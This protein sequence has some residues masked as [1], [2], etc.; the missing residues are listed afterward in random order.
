MIHPVALLITGILTAIVA[1]AL[2]VLCV[3]W[4][5]PAWRIRLGGR[6]SSGDEVKD[7]DIPSWPFNACVAMVSLG[8]G[9]GALVAW[10][11]CYW[12]IVALLAG[13]A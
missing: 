13:M 1:I 7:D 10:Y 11:G 5:V 8:I 6:K 2:T 3:V 12:S 4:M 9:G